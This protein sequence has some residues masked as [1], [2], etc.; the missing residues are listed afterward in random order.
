MMQDSQPHVLS[1]GRLHTTLNIKRPLLSAGAEYV[2]PWRKTAPVVDYVIF[3][4]P[5]AGLRQS[6]LKCSL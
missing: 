3:T 1:K 6:V 2:H 4:R 5:Y